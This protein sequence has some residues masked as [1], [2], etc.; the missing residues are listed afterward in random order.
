MTIRAPNFSACC[1]MR[2]ASSGPEMPS[3]KPG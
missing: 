3:G 1:T 2:L